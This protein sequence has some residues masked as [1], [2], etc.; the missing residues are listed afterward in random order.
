[1]QL[2]YW[3][4]HIPY[5]AGYN[6]R[7]EVIMF[8]IPCIILFRSWSKQWPALKMIHF[9][10]KHDCSIKVSIYFQSPF[11]NS[12]CLLVFPDYLFTNASTIIYIVQS[13]IVGGGQDLSVTNN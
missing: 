2:F 11:E 10:I 5:K 4:D 1:M 6:I 9:N 13:V 8:T 7:A 12:G 3:K